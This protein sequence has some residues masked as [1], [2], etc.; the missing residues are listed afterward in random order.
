RESHREAWGEKATVGRSARFF[1]CAAG[2]EGVRGEQVDAA[3]RFMSAAML[4][5]R[6][7]YWCWIWLAFLVNLALFPAEALHAQIQKIRISTSSRS[8]T[9]VAYYVAVSKGFLR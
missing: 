5:D 2:V 7:H 1:S 6:N 8:N 4:T 3:E 9:T